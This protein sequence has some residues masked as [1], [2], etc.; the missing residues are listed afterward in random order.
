MPDFFGVEVV[1]PRI[2][3]AICEMPFIRGRVTRANPPDWPYP[4]KRIC[5]ACQKELGLHNPGTDPNP[6]LNWA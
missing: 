4:H 3:C 1:Q 6:L 2:H 5:G